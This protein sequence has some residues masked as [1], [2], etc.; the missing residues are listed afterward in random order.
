MSGGQRSRTNRSPAPVYSVLDM[1]LVTHHKIV[2]VM[3]ILMKKL[4]QRIR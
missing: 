4:Q 3:S 2:E 1:K